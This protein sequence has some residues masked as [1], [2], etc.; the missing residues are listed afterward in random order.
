MVGSILY[1][2]LLVCRKNIQKTQLI[3]ITKYDQADEYL[4]VK[5]ITRKNRFQYLA[6]KKKKK[7]KKKGIK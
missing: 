1:T 7:M 5:Y 4:L 6:K 3:E 2:S